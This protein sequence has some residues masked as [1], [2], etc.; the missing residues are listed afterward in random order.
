MNVTGHAYGTVRFYFVTQKRKSFLD[1]CSVSR[2][3]VLPGDPFDLADFH[4]G[5]GVF[6]SRLHVPIHL[7]LVTLG[8]GAQKVHT[9]LCFH[10]VKET[11]RVKKK[12]ELCFLVIFKKVITAFSNLNFC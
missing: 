12:I 8:F 4:C 9:F 11:W 2:V 1:Q 6:G 10:P 3:G 7:P 5:D